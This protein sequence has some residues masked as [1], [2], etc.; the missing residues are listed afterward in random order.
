MPFFMEPWARRADFSMDEFEPRLVVPDQTRPLI[1]GEVLTQAQKDALP[2]VLRV[3]D[4]EE[5]GVLD[6]FGWAGNG[7][8]VICRKLRDKIQEMEPG[9][10][11]FVPIRVESPDGACDF[12]VYYHLIYTVK[13]DI[14]HYDRTRFLEGF[15][16][17]AA[18]AS[19]HVLC[20]GSDLFACV[21]KADV[22]EGRHLWRGRFQDSVL[23]TFCSD[24]LGEFMQGEGMRGVV[25]RK[26]GVESL[27]PSAAGVGPK[28]EPA[29]KV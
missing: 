1:L 8:W 27:P 11:D 22:V 20:G 19:R 13:L 29:R 5:T 23:G 7:K 2:K 17:A 9:V 14:F 26:C 6:V 18:E 25:L 10:H 12:G 21:L 24:E 28:P 16:R 4:L 3:L 15:G